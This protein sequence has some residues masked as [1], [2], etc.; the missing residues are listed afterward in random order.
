MKV[1]HV[2]RNHAVVLEAR[3]EIS[4][5]TRSKPSKN[6]YSRKTKHKGQEA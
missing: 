5:R 4:L 6:V 3:G 1:K 2:G